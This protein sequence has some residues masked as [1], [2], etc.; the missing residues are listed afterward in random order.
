MNATIRRFLAFYSIV[1]LIAIL[2]GNIDFEYAKR[3]EKPLFAFVRT[4]YFLDGGTTIWSGPGYQIT[5]YHKIVPSY[6]TVLP[7]ETLYKV[8]PELKPWIVF[9][10]PGIR[11]MLKREATGKRYY[12]EE[13]EDYI[14][15]DIQTAPDTGAYMVLIGNTI[16]DLSSF[17]ILGVVFLGY[18]KIA[19]KLKPK[20]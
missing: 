17:F 13:N 5:I 6:P 10:V 7:D 19:N 8:G 1:S 20:K 18:R 12:K 3:H 11:S 9:D 14:P 2:V 16:I 15:V 4:S